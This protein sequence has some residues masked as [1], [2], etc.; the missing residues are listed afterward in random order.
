M[1]TN[2]GA[3]EA[4]KGDLPT[5]SGATESCFVCH[6]EGNIADVAEAHGL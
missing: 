2:G 3:F 1:T 4:T 6:G 5:T